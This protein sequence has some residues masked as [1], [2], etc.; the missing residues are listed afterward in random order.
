MRGHTRHISRSLVRLVLVIFANVFLQYRGDNALNM[1]GLVQFSGDSQR[2]FHT[3]LLNIYQK[4]LKKKILT[5]RTAIHKTILL[6]SK[7]FRCMHLCKHLFNAV[8]IVMDKRHVFSISHLLMLRHEDVRGFL[9][10][11]H[12]ILVLLT[13]YSSLLKTVWAI[14]ALHWH[15]VVLQSMHYQSYP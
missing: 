10:W 1:H 12:C 11:L 3:L 6:L 9:R 8:R 14:G 2:P 7:C 15:L 13:A 5:D 4:H